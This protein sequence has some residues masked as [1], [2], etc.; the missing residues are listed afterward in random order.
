MKKLIFI[1][2][3]LLSTNAWADM[4][5]LLGFME[6]VGNDADMTNL[7]YVNYRCMALFGM[8]DTVKSSSTD[9]N[10]EIIKK[11]SEERNRMLLVTSFKLWTLLNEDKSIEAF[12]KNV[13]F[14]VPLL[15]DKYLGI[16]NEN[17]LNNGSYI[18]GNEL[19][20]EDLLICGR[21]VEM[22]K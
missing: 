16:A 4:K 8:L 22:N 3:M 9:K 18:V 10:S 17:Y 21:I 19:L 6:D 20:N 7:L 2:G 1:T 15:S 11:D 5:S 14:T 13:N 12:R